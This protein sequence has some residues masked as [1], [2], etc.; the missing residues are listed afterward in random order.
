MAFSLASSQCHGPKAREHTIGKDADATN[1]NLH[2]PLA[3]DATHAIHTV[4]A[5]V[6]AASGEA[7]DRPN[8]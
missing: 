4:G 2:E 6:P 7:M 5:A 1:F 8:D 3:A